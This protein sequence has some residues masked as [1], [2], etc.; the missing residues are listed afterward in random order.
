ML[1]KL[2]QL[3]DKTSK[4]GDY[5]NL[6]TKKDWVQTFA[7]ITTQNGSKSKIN[8]DHFIEHTKNFDSD[9]THAGLIHYV[10]YAWAIELGIQLR[11]DMILNA[12]ISEL[13][14]KILGNPEKYKDLFTN[15]VE[16]VDINCVGNTIFDID[17]I[18]E[19]V[20]AIIA[21]PEFLSV[22]CDTEFKSD[23]E[24]AK[25]ARRMCFACMGTPYFNYMMTMCGIPQ[26]E[27]IGK[28]SDWTKL[29]SVIL[30]LGKF[31]CNKN[32]VESANIVSNI[33]YYCFGTKPE[34]FTQ[35]HKSK[36][37]FFS[38]I[39][40][41]GKNKKCQSGH[42]AN[43]VSGWLR[44]F[45][46]RTLEK[47]PS[48]DLSKY[49]AHTNYLCVRQTGLA[50]AKSIGE[51]LSPVSPTGTNK[52]FC[53]VVSLAYSLLDKEK[54]ILVPH[55]G[56]I[57]YEITDECTF[58]NLAMI[59]N[60]KIDVNGIKYTPLTDDELKE[61]MLYGRYFNPTS[62]REMNCNLCR[63][64]K[65]ICGIGT[66]DRKNLCLECAHKISIM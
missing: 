61:I 48:E 40:H 5:Y 18:V 8:S 60:S 20:R 58:N 16:K 59:D 14:Q 4:P 11:P 6:N 44:V 12:I 63:K 28:K 27:V 9:I 26:I 29:R 15:S 30:L 41:Y 37:E 3:S 47:L 19:R 46:G 62:K 35:L 2:N 54:N 66:N 23:V 13:A 34:K 25:L 45:Y 65:L 21:N 56:I 1:I 52:M 31:A 7:T 22:I 33:I 24:N 64:N 38:D 39:F 17:Q 51:G 10:H 55:Y 42:D 50:S 36:E 53:Q 32:M 57:T 43:I 49:N